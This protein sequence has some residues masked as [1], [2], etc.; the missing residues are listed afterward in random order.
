MFIGMRQNRAIFPV[1]KQSLRPDPAHIGRRTEFATLPS[2]EAAVRC[3]SGAQV[4]LL[5]QLA[6]PNNHSPPRF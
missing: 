2:P 1:S 4:L 3:G 6:E 5:R